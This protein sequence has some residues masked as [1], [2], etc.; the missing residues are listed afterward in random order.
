MS[1][2]VNSNR[3]TIYGIVFFL[4]SYLINLNLLKKYGICTCVYFVIVFF[5]LFFRNNFLNYKLSNYHI[6]IILYIILL[7]YLL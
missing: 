1:L 7:G 3:V 6:Y 2:N 4:A 5:L